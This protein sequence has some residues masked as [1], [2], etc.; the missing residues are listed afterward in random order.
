MLA[1]YHLSFSGRF[2]FDSANYPFNLLLLESW[3]SAVKFKTSFSTSDFPICLKLLFP[4]SFSI[5][6]LLECATMLL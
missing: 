1:G 2:P 6:T 4:I 3:K 5:A